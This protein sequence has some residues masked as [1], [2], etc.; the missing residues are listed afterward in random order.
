MNTLRNAC[1]SLSLYQKNREMNDIWNEICFELKSCIRSNVLEKEYENAVCNCMVLLG[2]KKFRG[3]IV[4]QY[5]VQ[6][7]HENKYADIKTYSQSIH[8][9]PKSK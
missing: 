6:A 1:F 2:W 7:G 4:T 3:E 8:T 9:L 5:P